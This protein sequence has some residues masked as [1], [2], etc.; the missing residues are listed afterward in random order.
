[1]NNMLR[2][3]AAVGLVT[4]TMAGTI[5]IPTAPAN[6]GCWR[7]GPGW[8][9]VAA[10]VV[11][12]LALGSILGATAAPRYYGPPPAYYGPPPG[13]YYVRRPVYDQWGNY[14]GVRPVQVCQ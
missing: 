7:C 5:A 3:L 1:V 10:G 6:A 2:R 8:G 9:G 12:G 11:G 13:C 14:A 4:L